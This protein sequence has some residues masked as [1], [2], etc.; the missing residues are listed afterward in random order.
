[1]CAAALAVPVSLLRAEEAEGGPV[2][3]VADQPDP[4]TRAVGLI[5]RIC[6]TLTLGAPALLAGKGL[7]PR[8]SG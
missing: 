5:N 6:R 7:D 3:R 8:R 2:N 1:M 4:F